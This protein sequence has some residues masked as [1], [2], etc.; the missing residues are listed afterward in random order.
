LSQL[1]VS[2]VH[3]ATALVSGDPAVIHLGDDRFLQRLQSYLDVASAL[4]DQV[5]NIDYVDV[6]F[7]GRIYV[8]SAF[9]P[10]ALRRDKREGR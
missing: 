8:G 3:D 9:A 6:R 4:R 5:P 7:D 2:D 10:S 1:D